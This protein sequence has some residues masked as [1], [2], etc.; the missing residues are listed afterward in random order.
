MRKYLFALFSVAML[1]G[2]QSGEEEAGD[3]STESESVSEETIEQE[4]TEAETTEESTEESTEKSA[5][6]LTE[7]STD[8]E[9]SENEADNSEESTE[10]D[11]SSDQASGESDSEQVNVLA[12]RCIISNLGDCEGVPL[13]AQKAEY[14]RLLNEGVLGK[15][16]VTDTFLEDVLGSHL[17]MHNQNDAGTFPEDRYPPSSVDD[18]IKYFTMELENYYNGESEAALGYLKE[19]SSLYQSTVENKKAGDF[20]DYKLYDVKVMPL[21]DSAG[22]DSREIER[23]YSHAS[24]N[25]IER[26]RVSYDTPENNSG[27][28]GK[29]QLAAIEDHE[30]LEEN[31]D[32]E[33]EINEAY[34]SANTAPAHARE[35]VIQFIRTCKSDAVDDVRDAYDQYV[36]NGTLPEATEAESYPARID[37]SRTEIDYA[38]RAAGSM[39]AKNYVNYF[40][41]YAYDLMQYYNDKSDDVIYYLEPDSEAYD[42]IVANKETGNYN[43]HENY[44][45]NVD[46]KNFSYMSNPPQKMILERVYSHATSERKRKNSVL[47]KLKLDEVSGIKIIS[48]EE[49]SD[50]PFDE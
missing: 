36:A 25:G 13:E 35:C 2:C 29:I 37:E 14:E 23:V 42:A 7:E 40:Q 15:M 48:Y 46:D 31:I 41:H 27:D 9:G 21:E 50:E 4:T 18:T 8:S 44:L 19:G 16:D 11:T 45:V 12:T 43:D 32:Y 39:S 26:D 28:N 24:S 33:E 1:I 30:L 47:Y 10:S 34:G 49:L 38:I 5:E 6:D 3:T 20:M 17:T 22:P